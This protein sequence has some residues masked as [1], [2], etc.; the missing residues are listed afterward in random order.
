MDRRELSKAVKTLEDTGGLL[1]GFHIL[2]IK[3]EELLDRRSLVAVGSL[4]ETGKGERVR[5][6]TR[7]GVGEGPGGGGGEAPPPKHATDWLIDRSPWG[8]AGGNTGR[9]GG[10]GGSGGSNLGERGGGTGH[11]G[12]I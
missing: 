1:A 10:G 7:R 11:K 3:L 12:L 9:E 5:R 6:A 2:K 8:S 4:E